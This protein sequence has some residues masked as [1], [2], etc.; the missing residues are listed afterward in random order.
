[1]QAYCY[2]VCMTDHAENRIPWPKPDGYNPADYELVLRV[3]AA[4]LD[5]DEMFAKFDP[6]PN[7]KTDT[8]NHGP[9]SF[10]NIGANYDY[11]DASYERRK[12]ITQ[13]HIRYQQGLLYFLANDAR[14]PKAVRQRMAKWGLPKDE[15]LQSGG[16][17]HQLYIR[18]ARRLSGKHVMTENEL[19]RKRPTPESVGMGSYTID[20]HNVR[21]YVTADGRV[22]NEGDIGVKLPGPY[23]ISLGS[24]LPLAKE[25]ENLVV[26][27]CV[28]STHLAFGSIRM[29]P[30]FMILGQSAATVASLAIDT[31]SAVQAVP[32]SKVQQRL[33]ADSQIL[34]TP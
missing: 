18:E 25:A 16:W 8:N 9:F 28:S 15:F 23:E 17:P 2:R 32:Y 21:R 10:D 30:V 14:V 22:Q 6:I 33:I 19:L 29:E 7:H 34:Y 26:P 4:G 5:K 11:P 27:V 1:V 3:F 20:S 13:E 31:N 24:L 12:E